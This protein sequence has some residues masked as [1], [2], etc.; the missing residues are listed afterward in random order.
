MAAAPAEE[1]CKHRCILCNLTHEVE[2][3]RVHGRKFTCTPCASADRL[4]RRGLGS[5]DELQNL[6]VEEQHSFFQKLAVEKANAKDSRI[7]WKTVRACLVTSLTTRQMTEN[8]T[9]VDTQFLPLDV[10][11]KQGWPEQTVRNCPKEWNEQYGCD[12][13]QVPVKSMTW[14]QTYQAVEE[15]ILRQEK[16]ATAKRMARPRGPK[17]AEPEAALD[18]PAPEAAKKGDASAAAEK[19]AARAEAAQEKKNQASNQKMQLLAAKAVAPLAQDLQSLT[20]LRARVPAD[21]PEPIQAVYEDNVG[22]LQRWSQ[23]AKGLLKD[24]EEEAAQTGK[25]ALTAPPF[26]MADVKCLHKT[27]VE[28]QAN[29]RQHLPVPKAK[30]AGKRKAAE[31]GAE[32]TDTAAAEG[33][34]A[35]PPARRVRS[36]GGN[37]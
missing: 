24:W 25:V 8:A 12:T 9:A 5:K 23:A 17:E 36:K 4:L 32:A 15:R 22:K 21:L 33:A 14:K 35:N 6:S 31:A 19:K 28:V 37:K 30:A 1:A 11:L 27:V 10:W 29:L 3:G 18:L 16:E 2:S 7:D 26:D 34:E 20:K 13:Y